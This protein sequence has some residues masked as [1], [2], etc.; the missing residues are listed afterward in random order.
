MTFDNT[1]SIVV[2]SCD[3]Y[4]DILEQYLYYLHTNWSDCNYRILLGM[5]NEKVDDTVAESIICG[6]GSTWTQR[7][8]DCINAT[9][10]RYILLSV[11]DLFIGEKVN[12]ND[13]CEI[14]E[15]M[16]EEKIKYYRIPVFKFKEDDIQ[17]Y[18]GNPNA[19][20]IV[21]NKR[22]NVSIGT[23]IWDRNELLRILGD[24]S[25]TAWDLENY[26][27]KQA[28]NAE[29]GY[30]EKYVSDSRYVLHSVHMV[31]SGKWIPGSVK[32]M[33]KLGY[34]IDYK[35]RGYISYSDRLKLNKMYSW[36]S[37]KFPTWLRTPVKKVM[38]A[39]GFKF[40]SK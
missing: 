5:E 3:S 22:Y 8:I 34:T 12:S 31:K 7:A 18:P 32:K 33:E 4:K 26:F 1:M 24:G 29:P 19:E 20:L 2:V 28:E 39:F 21:R 9:N 14:L 36:C 40:A 25:M 38:T 37:R 16:K 23:A 35:E 15:F 17:T 30:L 11:D 6:K 13:F 27:L 10:S